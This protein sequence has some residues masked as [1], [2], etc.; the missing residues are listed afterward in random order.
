MTQSLWKLY[1]ITKKLRSETFKKCVT[2]DQPNITFACLK[3]KKKK[4]PASKSLVVKMPAKSNQHEGPAQAQIW[5][6]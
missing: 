6:F 5:R 1:E 4:N 2:T 3:K